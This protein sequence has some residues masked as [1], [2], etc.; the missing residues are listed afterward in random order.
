MSPTKIELS[1][2]SG[3]V[4][5][6]TLVTLLCQVFGARPMAEVEWYNGTLITANN[7]RGID[8][9]TIYEPNV[10]VRLG[11]ELD[12]ARTIPLEV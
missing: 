4:N 6:G 10:S 2:V 8:L 7:S 9:R 12:K 11:I 5:Q 3:H 1:G